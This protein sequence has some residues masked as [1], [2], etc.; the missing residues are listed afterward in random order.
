[1]QLTLLLA[2]QLYTTICTHGE[3]D[4]MEDVKIPSIIQANISL[5]QRTQVIIWRVV[6]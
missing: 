1:M 5:E 2:F 3:R 4:A 6:G